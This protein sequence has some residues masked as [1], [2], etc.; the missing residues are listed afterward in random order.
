MRRSALVVTVVAALTLSACGGNDNGGVAPNK[1][2]QSAQVPAPEDVNDDVEAD[3]ATQT[4][5]GGLDT[6]DFDAFPFPSCEL[7]ERQVGGILTG[8][9]SGGEEFF[10]PQRPGDTFGKTCT[11]T[12]AV[13]EGTD[14]ADLY[15]QLQ[16]GV[17]VLS[18]NVP[19]NPMSEEDAAAVG[20]SFPDL[21]AEQVGGYVFAPAETDLSQPLDL[22][23]MVVTVDG[24]DVVWS[25]G[26]GFQG[27]ESEVEAFTKDW[28]I[29][30]AA[31]VHRLIWD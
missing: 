3:A 16:T 19:A 23:G 9:E 12:S 10:P 1:P 30:A 13:S 7:V 6:S 27:S 5:G 11:W 29:E 21:R 31:T 24:V 20:Y 18:I 22:M 2:G 4:P 15:D 8:L 17:V 14:I 25:A 28:A 26:Q